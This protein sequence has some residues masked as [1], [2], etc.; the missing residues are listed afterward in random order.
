MH[1][2]PSSFRNLFIY[3]IINHLWYDLRIEFFSEPFSDQK[4]KLLGSFLIQQIPQQAHCISKS[5]EHSS[6]DADQD[7]STI[8]ADFQVGY[9]ILLLK[10]SATTTKLTICS[11]NK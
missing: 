6:M 1:K 4:V 8:L 11:Y 7:R 3:D 9:L 2:H 10:I 5:Q